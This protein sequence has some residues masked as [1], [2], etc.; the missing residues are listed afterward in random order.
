M[1]LASVL[2]KSIFQ[3]HEASTYYSVWQV[4]KL[5]GFKVQLS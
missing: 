3:M 1:D 4:K 2:H 5:E